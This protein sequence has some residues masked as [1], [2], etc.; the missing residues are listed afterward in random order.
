MDFEDR[1]DE[2]GTS[3]IGVIFDSDGVLVDSEPVSLEAFKRTYAEVGVEVDEEDVSAVI[4]RTVEATVALI[5]ERYGV[6]ISVNEF[7]SRKQRIYEELVNEHGI[8]TFPG[9]EELLDELEG[10][11]VPF[12]LASSGRPEKIE[13]NLLAAGLEGRFSLIVS[14]QDVRQGKPA[15]EMFL[16]A[17]QRLFLQPEKCVVIE[18]SGVGVEAARRAGMPCIAVTNT[19]PA[20]ALSAATCVVDSLESVNMSLLRRA[21]ESFASRPR[22]TA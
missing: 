11:G 5:F 10:E 19:F 14:G 15:P 2:S 3:G 13:L 9:V 4:G 20:R 12:A 22:N 17:A 1:Y 16:L 7:V 8:A 21:V 18:D 6:K